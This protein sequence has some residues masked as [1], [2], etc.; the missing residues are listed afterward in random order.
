MRWTHKQA[1]VFDTL[2]AAEEELAT[3][4]GWP[5]AHIR[6]VYDERTGEEIGYVIDVTD[7]LT[8]CVDGY[9]RRL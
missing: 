2:E 7:D 6:P 1:Q 8:L 4:L 5:A 3:M 9:T